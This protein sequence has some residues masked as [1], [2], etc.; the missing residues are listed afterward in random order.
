MILATTPG[1]SFDQFFRALMDDQGE[2]TWIR[3]LDAWLIERNLDIGS[4]WPE[5]G[6]VFEK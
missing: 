1:K 4:V 2:E 3:V 6:K 5:E